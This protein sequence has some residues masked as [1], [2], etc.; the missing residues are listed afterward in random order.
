M[1]NLNKELN[2]LIEKYGLT[3]NKVIEISRRLEQDICK[4]QRRRLMKWNAK[5][6][7]G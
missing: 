7:N 1:Q 2:R 3:H 6:V 4:E 5:S